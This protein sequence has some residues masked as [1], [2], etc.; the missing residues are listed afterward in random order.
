MG[1]TSR[2]LSNWGR[3]GKQDTLGTLNLLNAA[4]VLQSAHLI[5]LGRVYPLA[6]PIASSTSSPLRDGFLHA[7]TVRRDDTPSKRSV[8]VDFFAMDSHNFTHIDGLA[9]VSCDGLLYNGASADVIGPSGTTRYGIETVPPIVSRCVLADVASAKG[10]ECLPAGFA[11]GPSDIE[12]ALANGKVAVAEGDVLLVRTGWISAYLSNPRIALEGWP[13]L[14]EAAVAWLSDHGVAMVGADNLAV[15]VK[16]FE[17]PN[18]SLIVHE[19]YIRDLGGYLLEFV[20]LD[21]LA[22]DKFSQGLFVMAPLPIVGALG[23]PVSPVVI[24]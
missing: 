10:E 20:N 22:R 15:E 3:W 8:A 19:Q 9:H 11:I 12:Q 2:P 21:D 1:T 7:A 17:N 18:R 23:S 14:N 4:A 16:P 13:G 6:I 5:R 24:C